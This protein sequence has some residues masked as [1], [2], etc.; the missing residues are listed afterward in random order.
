MTSI[1]HDL[2]PTPWKKSHPIREQAEQA[3]MKFW[4]KPKR[5]AVMPCR[6]YQCPCGAWH[7]TS[8]PLRGRP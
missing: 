5:G 1:N 6:V 4:R 7:T 3:M 8:K 2:C